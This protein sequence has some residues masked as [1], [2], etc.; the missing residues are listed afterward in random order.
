[1]WVHG[2]EASEPNWRAGNKREGSLQP[3][4]P[5]SVQRTVGGKRA[6][7]CPR[8]RLPPSL[9]KRSS[10][11]PWPVMGLVLGLKKNA[12]STAPTPATVKKESP[13]LPHARAI[14]GPVA[15]SAGQ[16]KWGWGKGV[17]ARG[18]GGRQVGLRMAPQ[19]PCHRHAAKRGAKARARGTTGASPN[20]WGV[21]ASYAAAPALWGC[22]ASWAAGVLLPCLTQRV[23]AAATRAT[24]RKREAARADM[25][26]AKTSQG[27]ERRDNFFVS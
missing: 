16:S 21:C 19:H 9:L 13:G 4:L 12:S 14:G 10:A 22:A 23:G 17:R 20:R 1:M 2:C 18:R 8:P 6:A 24:R 3:A 25:E 11:H 26:I 15:G 27:A 7:P 5:W